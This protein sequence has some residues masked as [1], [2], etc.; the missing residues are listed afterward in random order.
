MR[1]L[2]TCQFPFV[3][4]SLT[5][6]MHKTCAGF[7]PFCTVNVGYKQLVSATCPRL[8]DVLKFL[9]RFQYINPLP[10]RKDPDL[11]A[12]DM[13]EGEKSEFMSWIYGISFLPLQ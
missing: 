4:L 1:H 7:L 2:S 12:P 9:T 10:G 5:Q 8:T 3:A 13:Q 6:R 11:H